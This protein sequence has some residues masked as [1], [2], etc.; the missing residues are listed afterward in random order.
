MEA[1]DLSTKFGSS[2]KSMSSPISPSSVM[3]RM[4]DSNSEAKNQMRRLSN[5]SAP[6]KVTCRTISAASSVGS[7][8]LEA[9]ED[10]DVAGDLD[11]HAERDA[12]Q[13]RRA[14]ADLGHRPDQEGALL[15]REDRAQVA[16]D[17]GRVLDHVVR[18]QDAAY[19]AGADA[20]RPAARAAAAVEPEQAADP[21]QR[22]AEA[23]LEARAELRGDDHEQREAGLAARAA[24]C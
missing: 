19:R 6:M 21:L 22:E 18:E 3:K 7:A 2:L 17:A 24:W 8:S 20:L 10:H 14:P 4:R 23:E 12:D 15:R 11:D 5:S 13:R 16:D 9:P 1:A